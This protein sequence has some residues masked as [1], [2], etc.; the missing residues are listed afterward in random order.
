M[1]EAEK[2]DWTKVKKLSRRNKAIG[3]GG[4]IG[5]LWKEFTRSTFQLKMSNEG[6]GKKLNK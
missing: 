5:L 6:V 1:D 2:E 4:R 3:E